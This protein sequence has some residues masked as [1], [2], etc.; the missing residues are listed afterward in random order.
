M[1][2][3]KLF[4][5]VRWLALFAILLQLSTG[6]GLAVDRI[7]AS[8]VL[9]NAP[10]TNGMTFVV[11][12]TTV[13]TRTWTN[14]VQNSA[15]QIL[16]NSTTAGSA[17]NLANHLAATPIPGMVAI[18][19]GETN[20]TLYGNSGV[21]IAVTGVGNYFSV[22]YSTQSVTAAWTVRVPQTVE[23]A[24][25]RTNVSSGLVDWLNYL[26]ATNQLAQI[27]PAMSQLLGTTNTQTVTG[28]KNFSNPDGLWQGSVS[29]SPAMYGTNIYLK[30]GSLY[31]FSVITGG[32]S[33]LM[34]FVPNDSLT[35]NR[36]NLIIS[37]LVSTGDIQ[38]LGTTSLGTNISMNGAGAFFFE[39]DD[40]GRLTMWGSSGGP[41]TNQL[42]SLIATQNVSATTLTV[43]NSALITAAT[44]SNT[45]NFPT[46]SDI[47]FGRFA[48]TSLANGNNAAVPVGTNV[49]IEVSGPSG[50]FAVHGIN[51]GTAMRDGKL[52]VI[53][54]QTG[55]DMTIAHQSGTDPAA[56]NRIIT[57]TG[58]DRATT[59]NG[60]ATLIYS[61]AASR[62]ILV[63]FD[64]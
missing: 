47:A 55:Q 36:P 48:V 64:P 50:A 33:N 43:S 25:Q 40:V 16:T 44:F 17:T 11:T 57:M 62:W 14:A 21:P 42:G 35:I 8:V 6:N 24:A 1:T 12:T 45:N 10:T 32:Y 3:S 4:R 13:N 27:S 46:H 2:R 20:V 60:A 19:T 37:N 51:A 52:I 7:T 41:A 23:S 58:A 59:G 31:G 56:A 38:S 18:L 39:F 9:T 49:F 30:G 29:N 61:G 28:G 53:L 22:T 34:S 63:S 15:T 54:N 26:G 5:A